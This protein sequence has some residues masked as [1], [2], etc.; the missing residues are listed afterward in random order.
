MRRF[1]P[2]ENVL[3]ATIN[4]GAQVKT[5]NSTMEPTKA[6]SYW[7]RIWNEQDV[8]IMVFI[9]LEL[10]LLLLFTGTTRRRCRV[11]WLRFLVWLAYLASYAVAASAIGL[12]SQYEDKYKLRSLESV[13]HLQALTLPFLWPPFLLHLGGPDSIT[14]FSIEDNNLW[15]RQLINLMFQL[16]LAL[17]VF[18]KSFDLLDSQLIIVAV[19]LFVAR[20]IKYWERIWA[21]KRGS[22]DS[23]DCRMKNEDPN[24]PAPAP[25]PSGDAVASCA[26]N[27]GL[28]GRGLLV[29]RTLL[30]LGN[31]AEIEV[32]SAFAGTESTERKLKIILTEL[33]MIYDMLYTKTMV[34]HSRTGIMLRC[35]ALVAMVVAYVLLLGN[36][37]MNDQK[38]INHALTYELLLMSIC[39]E[40]F[41][42]LVA[43]ASPWTRARFNL[44]TFFSWLSHILC[45]LTQLILCCFTQVLSNTY[46]GQFNLADY[47]MSKK[48]M[49][50]FISEVYEALG[51]EKHWKNFWHIKHVEDKVIVLYIVGLFGTEPNHSEGRSRQLNLG[52][53]LKDLLNLPFEHTIFRLHIWTELHLSTYSLG[54]GG[55]VGEM[56]LL[57]AECRK[58]SNYL[59]YL[60]SVCPSML[61][62]SSVA[63]DFEPLFSEWVRDNHNNLTKAEVLEKYANTVLVG[64][65]PFRDTPASVETLKDLK[66]VWARLLI[67]AAGKC[68]FQEHAWQLG[69]GG[70]EL[71]TVIG[72]L[73]MH[74]QLGDVGEKVEL[75]PSSFLPVPPQPA[76]L[77]GHMRV[78]PIVHL[79]VPASVQ[80]QPLYAFEFVYDDHRLPTSVKPLSLSLLGLGEPDN[81]EPSAATQVTP[82]QSTSQPSTSGGTNVALEIEELAGGHQ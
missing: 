37:H 59:M 27:L 53:E 60:M 51:L 78:R 77:T 62:V 79:P 6:P 19:P 70:V 11:G 68:P 4:L 16:G 39:M 74:Q 75:S 32:L 56:S 63:R 17:Y 44:G 55:V 48:F 30:Q 67:Y 7:T 72:Y 36:Q 46:M 38:G 23:L 73:M 34:L 18:W 50:K 24:S 33:G 3:R 42:I 1:G 21:L 22:R 10:Q 2:V 69:N 52:Q 61:P 64:S 12:F 54:G 15:T 80:L 26:L 71:I 9:S 35:I 28:S 57:V 5:G 40:V 65:S 82:D 41:S 25:A 81:P 45:C 66:E 14:A 8:Q 76:S 43:I 47:S 31:R 20:M 13:E 29:G 49:S 58:L